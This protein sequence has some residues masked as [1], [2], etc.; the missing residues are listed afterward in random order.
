MEWLKIHVLWVEQHTLL[1]LLEP[2]Y[3]SA[4][5]SKRPQIIHILAGKLQQPRRHEFKFNTL[6]YVK[7]YGKSL[8]K[9]KAL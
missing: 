2:V 4:R 7:M 8:R 1:E 5:I 9:R 3:E 6:I